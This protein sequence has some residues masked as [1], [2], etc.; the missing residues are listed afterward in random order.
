MAHFSISF[1]IY[2]FKIKKKIYEYLK[3]LLINTMSRLSNK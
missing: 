3:E 1:L 2:F